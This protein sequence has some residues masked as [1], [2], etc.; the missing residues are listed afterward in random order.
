MSGP[1][2]PGALR[3]ALQEIV[4]EFVATPPSLRLPLLLEY[5]GSLPDLPERLRGRPDLMDRVHECQTPFHV[6]A[7][8]QMDG[9]VI[10]HFDAPPEAPTT[11]GFAGVLS[12]GL[13]G[14]RREE[15]LT[16]PPDFFV[17]MGLQELVSPLRMRGMGAILAHLKRVLAADVATPC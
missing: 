9:T 14:A 15:I 3:P 7:W 6:A 1:S 12:T 10:L 2:A 8:P 17:G 11:R 5:A 16:T 4:E 13:S